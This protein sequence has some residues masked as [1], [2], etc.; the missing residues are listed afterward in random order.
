MLAYQARSPLRQACCQIHKSFYIPSVIISHFFQQEL[1][2]KLQ[3]E[4]SRLAAAV[5]A[6]EA[7]T[8]SISRPS[9]PLEASI[10]PIPERELT[11]R[12]KLEDL[13]DQ[14][15]RIFDRE[16]SCHQY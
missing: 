1:H 5:Q 11:V 15:R 6:C 13:I 2:N 16:S 14:V 8:A 10:H 9:S 3:M 7:A 12:A 4:K